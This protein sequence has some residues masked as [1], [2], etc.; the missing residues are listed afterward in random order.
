MPMTLKFG[1][2]DFRVNP[3]NFKI[4]GIFAANTIYAVK[5]SNFEAKSFIN[6]AKTSTVKLFAPIRL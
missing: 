3:T 5:N 1:A 2:K 4:S 6:R